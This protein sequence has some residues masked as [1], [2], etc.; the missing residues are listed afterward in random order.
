MWLCVYMNVLYANTP[1]WGRCVCLHNALK[2][3]SRHIGLR[4]PLNGHTPG[5]EVGSGIYIWGPLTASFLV[6]PPAAVVSPHLMSPLASWDIFTGF[7][8]NSGN[9]LAVTPPALHLAMAHRR[10]LSKLLKHWG[11]KRWFSCVNN[12]FWICFVTLISWICCTVSWLEI[13]PIPVRFYIQQKKMLLVMQI[14]N[15]TTRRL[16]INYRNK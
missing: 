6:A 2:N 4:G 8:T 12:I 9:D 7:S 15:N 3:D 13:V 14:F 1:V 10:L 5:C 11:Q 16:K